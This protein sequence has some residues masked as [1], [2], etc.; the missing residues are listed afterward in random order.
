MFPKQDHHLDAFSAGEWNINGGGSR[1]TA[2]TRAPIDLAAKLPL[3]REAG[4]QYVEFHDTELSAQE[5]KAFRRIIDGEG[6]K[7]GMVTANL[8]R[9]PEFINGALDSPDA[10]VR[11]MAIDFTKAYYAAGIE[12]LDAETYVYWNGT[13]GFDYVLA[14]DH[15]THLR[16][17]AEGLNEVISW[18]LEQFGEARMIPFCIEPKPNEPRN[19]MYMGTVGDALGLIA[20]MD[21]DL[22]R[23]VGVN[24]ELAHS[25][26]AGLSFSHDISLA[27]LARKLW[28]IHL[29][30]QNGPRYDQDYAFGDC[31]L[32]E[33]LST[34]WILRQHNYR[35]LV[36]LDVQPLGTDSEKQYAETIARSVRNFKRLDAACDRI[37]AGAL[38]QMQAKSDQ[39]GVA[40][41]VAKALLS[42]D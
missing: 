1:F 3:I 9:R 14:K 19:Y 24:P 25:K 13:A 17:L 38:V 11:R 41:L 21:P 18:A 26:M 16:Y 34:V 35:G 2:G 15:V 6:L 4:C 33:A 23:Y 10:K 7:T 39:A 27:L 22:S 20:C 8:F 37:D 30:D 31:D 29:N 40:D 32:L 42:V 28:H 12:A 5:T 36:G